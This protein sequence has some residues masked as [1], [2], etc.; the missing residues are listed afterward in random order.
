MTDDEVATLLTKFSSQRVAAWQRGELGH[1]TPFG[2]PSGIEDN[3]CEI[4]W[5]I[6]SKPSR[7][8]LLAAG[9]KPE[10][11]DAAMSTQKST[12]G[13]VE[14]SDLVNIP[15]ELNE[16]IKADLGAALS[17]EP[18]TAVQRLDEKW[19]K[20]VKEIRVE[21]YFNEGQHRGR[22]HVAIF[23]Q[24]GK[25]SV[26]LEDPPVLLTP[27]GYRG[28]S[29]ALKVVAKHRVGLLELW[30]ETRPDDQKLPNR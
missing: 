9:A 21:I 19:V 28:E 17:D 26:S 25:V 16:A 2:A 22:P 1:E 3:I 13:I 14:P 11:I 8:S 30:N 18:E 23:L 27:N 20:W 24:D 10:Q 15:T 29:S 4:V 6:G 5:Y 7:E 12:L